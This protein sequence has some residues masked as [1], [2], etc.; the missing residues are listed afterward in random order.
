VIS[1]KHILIL[2]L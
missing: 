2:L 1:T